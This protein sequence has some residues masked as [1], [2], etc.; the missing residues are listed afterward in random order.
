MEDARHVGMA[1]A[2]AHR[3]EQLE[4][5]LDPESALIAEGGDGLAGHVLHGDERHAVVGGAGL[6]DPGDVG[7]AHAREGLAFDREAAA[8]IAAPK[9]GPHHLEGNPALDRRALLGEVDDAHAAPAEG[10][11]NPVGPDHFGP[12]RLGC[13]LALSLRRQPAHRGFQESEELRLLGEQGDELVRAENRHRRMPCRGTR[14]GLLAERPVPRR[15]SSLTRRSRSRLTT[16]AAGGARDGRHASRAPRSPPRFRAPRPS[17]RW[18]DHR[19]SAA[20]QPS[21]GGS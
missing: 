8:G 17:L 18:S 14:H 19:S 20:R 15:S 10:A 4:A 3:P 7:V 1:D 11:E 13:A 5:R 2:V 12:P 6:E 9:A 21:P 16:T